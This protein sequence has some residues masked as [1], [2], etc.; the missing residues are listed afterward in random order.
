MVTTWGLKKFKKKMWA[1]ASFHKSTYA[2]NGVRNLD[3]I[4]K[5][6]IPQRYDKAKKEYRD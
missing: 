4:Y 6:S 1:F 3:G 2:F 5:K